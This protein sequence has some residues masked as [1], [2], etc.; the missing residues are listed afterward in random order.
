NPTDDP[1]ILWIAG[2]P[3]CTA[4]RAAFYENGPLMFNYANS[5]GNIP[6]L[7]L[8]PYSWTKV[9]NIIFIDQPAGCGFSY[10]KTWKAYESN[11]TISAALN[12]D[13][14]RKWLLDHPKFLKNPLYICGISYI[15]MVIPIIV[16]DI[17]DGNEAGNEPPMNI[18]GYMLTNP[19]TDKHG[20]VNS[21]VR[22]AH[23]MS[24]LSDELY[25][26]TKANCHGEYIEVDPNNGLCASDL[27]LVD[28]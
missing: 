18:K 21:R 22:Y 9:A 24:L 14:L 1:L 5:S 13:F 11:D 15:G 2:G 20:D 28:K 4:L 19:L 6:I 8:N 27:Q 16:Q 26:S 10:A 3:G 23:H 25:E 7:E 17:Y 12:Y